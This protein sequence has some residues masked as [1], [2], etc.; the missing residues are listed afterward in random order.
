M[1]LC[2]AL[3]RWKRTQFGT[4]TTTPP[5]PAPATPAAPATPVTTMTS[6]STVRPPTNHV[7]GKRA[8]HPKN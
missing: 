4:A 2:Q 5:P 7:N 6:P 8:V 1:A 3:A